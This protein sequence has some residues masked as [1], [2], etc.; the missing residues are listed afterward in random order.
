[1]PRKK[2]IAFDLDDTLIP[3]SLNFPVEQQG[4]VA[5]FLGHESIREGTIKLMRTLRKEGWDIGIYTTPFRRS[6]YI[7]WLFLL[8]GIRI[9][10][11]INQHDHYKRVSCCGRA[12]QHCSKYPPKFHIDLLVDESEG[13]W[14][15]SQKYGF[16]IALVHPTELGWGDVVLANARSL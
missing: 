10:Y 13:V 8:Y 9:N 2:R 7:K 6:T 16:R 5:R 15:E 12:Y 3:T 1:M 14:I 11:V 4:W